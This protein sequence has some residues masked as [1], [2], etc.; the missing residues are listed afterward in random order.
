MSA[1]S[2][3]SNLGYGDIFP[4]SNIN[5]S[6]ANVYSTNNPYQFGS[7]EV[8]GLPGLSGSKYNVDAAKGIVPG[9]CLFKGGTKQFKQKIKNITK[10]YKMK[11][12]SSRNTKKRN[13]KKLIKG[14]YASRTLARSRR[15]VGGDKRKTRKNNKSRK[16]IRGGYSQYYNNLPSTPSYS[17]GGILTASQLGLANP[18]PITSDCTNC[19]DNYDHY[20]NKGFPSRGH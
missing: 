17:V 2:D 14:R 7:N 18:P 4:L 12:K 19:V 3:A 6:Y 10:Q 11:N 15:R 20:T 16:V 13:V 8:P 1:G 5:N 9:I